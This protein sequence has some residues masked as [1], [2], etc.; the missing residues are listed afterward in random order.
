M[1]YRTTELV[2]EKDL[3]AG[4]G[5]ETIDINIKDIISRIQIQFRTKNPSGALTIQET[6]AANLPKIELVDG[7]TVLY[8]LSGMQG[9]AID[10][11][12]TLVPNQ[13]NGSFVPNWDLLACVNINFGRKLWDK[14]LAFD[15]KRFSNPQLKVTYDEDAAVAS[16]IVNGLSVFADV[17]DERVVSPIGFLLNKEHKSYTATA[18]AWE[19]TDMPTD[20]PLRK[21]MVQ[22]RHASWW[23]GALLSELKLSEDNDK[24]I[25]I[26]MTAKFLE[27]W[28]ESI[29]PPYWQ[30]LVADLDQTTGDT[31][32]TIPTQT[33]TCDGNYATSAVLNGV[34]FSYSQVY[35]SGVSA[36]IG[37]QAF[38]VVGNMPHGCFCIP[39]GNQQD[40][41]DWYDL[42]GKSLI[43]KLKAGELAS[44]SINIV[45]QQLKRY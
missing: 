23:F 44:G 10:F 1:N 17:F 5:T 41:D 11:F 27:R 2:A 21:L 37:Y 45:T 8:S 16:T 9:Q 25:P 30:H 42:I 14:E 19:E 32:Y 4:A 18:N 13:S 15:P 12:D 34:P 24:R 3:T 22:I 26:Y 43:L 40:M 35:K 7:S 28:L 6:E 31:L 29:W 39:F 38:E 20:L 36:D 33:I